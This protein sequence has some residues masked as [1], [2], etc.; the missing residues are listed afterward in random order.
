MEPAL[1]GATKFETEDTIYL[2]GGQ[3]ADDVPTK[4]IYKINRNNP[5]KMEFVG[6]M[7]FY[8]TDP[9]VMKVGEYI[10]VLGGADKPALEAFHAKNFEPVEGMDIRAKPFFELLACYTSDFKL[11]N[12]S[13][14]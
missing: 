7:K 6:K 5:T 10:V 12:C 11:E 9:F 3:G 8:R 4:G 1:N 14:C 13:Y 2:F